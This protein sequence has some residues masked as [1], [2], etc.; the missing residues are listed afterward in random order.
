MKGSVS[1]KDETKLSFQIATLDTAAKTLTVRECL[2]NTAPGDPL[3]AVV[4]GESK[5]VSLTPRVTQS[6]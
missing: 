6:N 2:W 1:A 3:E 4:W 5:T